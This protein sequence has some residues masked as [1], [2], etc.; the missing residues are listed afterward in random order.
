MDQ[1]DRKRQR[2]PVNTPDNTPEKT[3]AKNAPKLSPSRRTMKRQ[4]RSK[5]K[6]FDLKEQQII[7]KKEEQQVLKKNFVKI[8]QPEIM[9]YNYNENSINTFLK[10]Y[11][12]VIQLNNM[13]IDELNE[14]FDIKLKPTKYYSLPNMQR[15]SLKKRSKSK[16]MSKKKRTFPNSAPGV[17]ENNYNMFDLKKQNQQN[18]NIPMEEETPPEISQPL[19]RQRI[20]NNQDLI[21]NVAMTGGSQSNCEKLISWCLEYGI[22]DTLHDFGKNRNYVFP[23]KA[24]KIEGKTFANLFLEKTKE[25]LQPLY[26]EYF[27]DKNNVDKYKVL[28]N[29]PLYSIYSKNP[30]DFEEESKTQYLLGLLCK[31]KVNNIQYYFTDSTI[32]ESWS[33]EKKQYFNEN[34]PNTVGDAFYNVVKDYEYY[35][36]DACLFVYKEPNFKGTGINKIETLSNLWDPFGS[37]NYKI[38][39][40]WDGNTKGQE[41]GLSF[42]REEEFT[43]KN[44]EKYKMPNEIIYDSVYK[45]TNDSVEKS[46]YDETYDIF[47]NKN[48]LESYGIEIKLRLKEYSDKNNEK[49]CKISMIFTEPSIGGIIGKTI[50]NGIENG[51]FD[52]DGGF[53]VTVL[54]YGL[55]YIETDNTIDVPLK[56]RDYF[57]KLKE[58]IDFVRTILINKGIDKE[59][60]DN[61]LYRMITRFKS[62]GDHGTANATKILNNDL[63]KSTLYLT[64]DQLAYVYSITNE[65][66]TLFRFYNGK[67]GSSADD[68]GDTQ[69]ACDR[70]HFV[71]LYTGNTN[72]IEL[73]QQKYMYVESFFKD[74]Q[75]SNLEN[76]N[77][78]STSIPE[79]ITILTEINEKIKALLNGLFKRDSLENKNNEYAEGVKK[80]ELT[81]LLQ[82]ITGSILIENIQ[83]T[84][85]TFKMLNP[86][87]LKTELENMKKYI[88]LLK[89]L[90]SYFIIDKNFDSYKENMY[91]KIKEQIKD[92]NEI[93]KINTDDIL[94][95][96]QTTGRS[97]RPDFGH[98]YEFGINGLLSSFKGK[99]FNSFVDGIK[100]VPVD[101]RQ[102]KTGSGNVTFLDKVINARKNLDMRYK[103]LEEY[104]EKE[105]FLSSNLLKQYANSIFDEYKTALKEKTEKIEKTEKS[106]RDHIIRLFFDTPLSNLEMFST[107]NDEKQLERKR[108]DEEKAAAKAT[109]DAEKAAA[110]A[111]KTAKTA[112]TAKT[113]PIVSFVKTANQKLKNVFSSVGSK[114]KK[115]TGGKRSLSKKITLK[116]RIS[117]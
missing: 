98:I 71:G 107:K 75:I 22:P 94:N 38:D 72:E 80:I 65:T 18:E 32:P 1:K 57:G 17:L 66:P 23:S 52:I 13:I 8:N 77:A 106:V 101:E 105:L 11:F 100:S 92:F 25:F 91:A 50:R 48:C 28:L 26:A 85:D 15:S 95:S 62:T 34:K 36:F 63:N 102:S 55:L 19:K 117:K 3:L 109:K 61:L 45:K 84:I 12:L 35:I 111:L 20:D 59:T 103:K 74:P 70:V 58:I 27:N 5:E 69:E 16:S 7:S 115:T 82:E 43:Q 44:Q 6:Q 21:K 97:M 39:D 30:H 88:D 51:I 89:E 41:L 37:T 33:A 104:I 56:Q 31:E 83:S 90:R 86:D 79:K 78:G 64:G 99:D 40:V 76:T 4:R 116:K 108:K 2:S 73:M 110:K 10:T 96:K 68:D 112:K 81:R 113:G 46:F 49:F 14:L 53:S 9:E 114:S 67:G 93:F 60:T 42:K 87:S 47:L 24:Q 54:S 29:D